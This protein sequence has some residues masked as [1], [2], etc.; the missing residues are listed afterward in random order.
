MG[1]QLRTGRGSLRANGYHQGVILSLGIPGEQ[2]PLDYAV[3]WVVIHVSGQDG[4][5]PIGEE[6][7]K[8]PCGV[9]GV[10]VCSPALAPNPGGSNPSEP[11]MWRQGD[12]ACLL[13]ALPCWTPHSGFP[14]ALKSKTNMAAHLSRVS[15]NP[16]SHLFTATPVLEWTSSIPQA[17]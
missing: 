9:A 1:S 6:V 2:F 17:Q 16:Q 3:E 11:P 13:L 7:V 5:E 8:E 15:C 12:T 14:W 10:K 4:M